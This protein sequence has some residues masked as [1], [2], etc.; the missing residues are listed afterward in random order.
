M[1]AV[2][3]LPPPGTMAHL[4]FTTLSFILLAII[5]RTNLLTNFGEE[6]LLVLFFLFLRLGKGDMEIGSL[7]GANS[8]SCGF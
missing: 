1:T 8:L 2:L 4:P 5:R 6:F 7:A 3:S